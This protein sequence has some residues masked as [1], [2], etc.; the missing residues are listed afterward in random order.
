MA[1][2]GDDLNEGSYGLPLATIQQALDLALEGDEIRL[3]AGTYDG[4]RNRDLDFGGKAVTLRSN[5]GDPTQVIVDCGG[6][7]AEPHRFAVF[8]AGEDSTTVVRG[9][10]IT[11]GY[12]AEWGGAVWVEPEGPT[13][14]AMSPR[15]L[16]CVFTD[17]AAGLGGGAFSV[18]YGTDS[19]WPAYH[20]AI[21]EDCRFRANTAPAGGALYASL[22]NSVDLRRCRFYRN[23]A[24]DGGAVFFAWESQSNLDGCEF[25]EN[26]ATGSGGAVVSRWEQYNS[27]R[28]TRFVANTAVDHGGAIE[29]PL[30]YSKAGASRRVPN[31]DSFH[32]CDFDSNASD[33]G[34]ALSVFFGGAWQFDACRFRGNSAGTAGGAFWGYVS[35][36]RFELSL[37]VGNQAPLGA[38]VAWV[39][40]D[41]PSPFYSLELLNCT[42]T[43]NPGGAAVAL[44]DLQNHQPT[45]ARTLVAFNDG[46]AFEVTGN[47]LPPAISSTDAFGNLGG[48][49]PAP[50]DGMV[51]NDF[52]LALDPLFCDPEADVFTLQADSPCAPGNHPDGGTDLIGAF[53]VGC[54]LAPELLS[55]T[56][57]PDDN[58][59]QLRLVWQASHRD[60]P[61]SPTPI[62]GYGIYRH[63]PAGGQPRPQDPDR[64]AARGVQ[65]LVDWDYLATVPARGDD[66]YQ[67]VAAT[68]C[69]STDAG[70]CLSTFLVSAM[71]ADPYTFWDSEP[72]S[73]Y[74]VDNLVPGVP[75][76]LVVTYDYGAGHLLTWNAPD[77]P[78]LR[79]YRIY[80]STSPDFVPGP[81]NQVGA[82]A[83]T[84]WTDTAVAPGLHYRVAAV[85]H[86]GNVGLAAEPDHLAGTPAF[87]R[88]TRVVGAW[89][90]PFNPST[91]INY[92]LA[93]PAAVT[94]RVY[95]V[96]GRL[97]DTP[98]RG[99]VAPAGRHA[100]SWQ[101]RDEAGRP[102]AAGRYLYVFE[103]GGVREVRGLTLLK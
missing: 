25:R 101:G 29:N 97:V 39:G 102:L 86:A 65:R 14:P 69:D 46:P 48:D 32:A 2:D 34:G 82:C 94:L 88:A 67:Y 91:T 79:E 23:Q 31:L 35:P 72:D 59:G 41:N 33:L 90:N 89:P 1:E 5:S 64:P 6:S 71:T 12:A 96:A 58:G 49:W 85:D 28:T 60:R 95:D 17:N 57:V 78:D 45:I 11:G 40:D 66:A 84:T 103:A 26:S 53:D 80:R 51:G 16:D 73:G 20:R 76:G 3:F 44:L 9:M 68:L 50:V 98:L 81:D 62:T 77:A 61:G 38:A 100:V 27:F 36:C 22:L 70:N 75:L 8:Q 54:N 24:A 83:T 10:T 30:G 87:A 47:N 7:I 37:F 43:G 19:S 52:N 63:A 15:F 42:V 18:G 56:D 55:L 21:F 13:T 92:E 74:S 99:A 4:D 93:E